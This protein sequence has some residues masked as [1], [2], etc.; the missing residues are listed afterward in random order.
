M[1]VPP[2]RGHEHQINHKEESYLICQTPYRY[3]YYQKSEIEKIV[4][5]LLEVG[6]IQNRIMKLDR[7]DFLGFL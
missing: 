2:I 4:K 3:S 1:G 6:S 7:Y 5:E